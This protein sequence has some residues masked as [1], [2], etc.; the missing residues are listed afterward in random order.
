[1]FTDQAGL[2]SPSA[3]D[4]DALLQQCRQ[5][6]QSLLAS[7]RMATLGTMAC[8][9]AH[10]FNNILTPMMNFAHRALTRPQDANLVH[11]ALQHAVQGCQRA[12]AISD[13]LLGFARQTEQGSCPSLSQSVHEALACLARSPAKDGIDIQIDV[14]DLPVA[15]PPAHLQ[16]VLLNLL[17][18]SV[19]AL[20]HRGGWIHIHAAVAE[21]H[22]TLTLH[23]NGPG[24]PLEL[25]PHLF[26]PFCHTCRT[27]ENQDSSAIP[28]NVPAGAGLGLSICRHLLEQ[29]GG[30]IAFDPTL[31]PGAA[32]H[33]TLPLALA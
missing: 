17:L 15:V 1:M 20:R 27:T 21:R 28:A 23:D 3:A 2:A 30:D 12:A 11:K 8:S 16:Q 7:H 13:S 22:V 32:F 19:R 25:Q 29:A 10:E 9:I 33:L 24:I 4:V 31:T 5:L 14:P 18:N 26:R 6:Q